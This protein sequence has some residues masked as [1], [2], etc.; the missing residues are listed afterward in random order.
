MFF[1]PGFAYGGPKAANLGG[2]AGQCRRVVVLTAEVLPDHVLRPTGDQ[3]LV[4]Q[5]KGVFEVEQRRHQPDRQTRP[6]GGT[7]AG[8]HNPQRRPE[9]VIAWHRM[10]RP[11]L[12]GKGQRQSRFDLA[13]RHSTHQHRQGKTEINHLIE[14]GAEKIVGSH[15]NFPQ[16]LSGFHDQY[17]NF[18]GISW[19]DFPAQI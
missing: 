4:A 8:A 1:H 14:S 3:F 6:A 11:I 19:G 5:I 10:A 16:F 9:Q 12:A 13:P 15:Q 7:N 2:L 18:S 17:F